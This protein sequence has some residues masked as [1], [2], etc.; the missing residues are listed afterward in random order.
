MFDTEDF[1]ILLYEI[2]VIN[3]SKL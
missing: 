3:C 1:I 2:T